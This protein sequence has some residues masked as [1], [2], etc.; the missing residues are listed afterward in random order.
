[1]T[2]RTNVAKI[3]AV[4]LAVSCVFFGMAAV[5]FADDYEYQVAMKAGNKGTV[6]GTSTAK[7]GYG[8]TYD[9]STVSVKVNDSKYYFKGWHEAGKVEIVSGAQEITRDVTYVAAYGIAGNQTSYTVRYVDA[10]TKK[11][12]GPSKTFYGAVNEKPVIVFAYFD[13][14]LPQAY[15]LTKTL[16]EN[17]A[18]NV[19]TFEYT[20]KAASQSG[21]EESGGN[22]GNG[23]GTAND[24][25]NGGNGAGTTG[26]NGDGTTATTESGDNVDEGG[27]TQ[28]PEEII[29]L[30]PAPK[31]ENP[32]EDSKG[33][34]GAGV[35]FGGAAIVLLMIAAGAV[36]LKRRSNQ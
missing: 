13:G 31:A 16:S 20:A 2:K 27:T 10:K 18:D 26:D 15:R 22:G 3:L 34:I 35:V 36:L 19:F 4:L 23:N 7:V 17:E 33:G 29:D 21:E 1:M 11:E 32:D 9:P 28:E 6:T 30:D 25:D 8:D 24:N 5:S 12:L 14:Y